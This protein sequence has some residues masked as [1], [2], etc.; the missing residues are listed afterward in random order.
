MS[1]AKKLEAEENCDKSDNPC[2]AINACELCVHKDF[3]KVDNRCKVCELRG[4][5]FFEIIYSKAS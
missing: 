3:L 2:K 1:A 4:R 5:R